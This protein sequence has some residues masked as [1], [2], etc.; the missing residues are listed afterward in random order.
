[1]LH[2][3]H[4]PSLIKYRDQWAKP[5]GQSSSLFSGAGSSTK[6][7]CPQRNKFEQKHNIMQL[8]NLSWLIL[9]MPLVKSHPL[10]LRFRSLSTTT[11]VATATIATTTISTSVPTVTS[12]DETFNLLFEG[13]R[14]FRNNTADLFNKKI[15]E[16]ACSVHN[17]ATIF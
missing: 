8:S 17:I 7:W 5:S 13:N 15:S 2:Q 10:D 12:V 4:H 16:G 1:M 3:F 11:T 14:L 6:A 9:F